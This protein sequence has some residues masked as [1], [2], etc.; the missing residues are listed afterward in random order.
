MSGII[1]KIKQTVLPSEQADNRLK[2]C[3]SCPHFNKL[4]KCSLC[5]C[6]MPVKT[7]IAAATCPAKKW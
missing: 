4:S 5:G 1:N 7:R 6:Y 3:K 2:I